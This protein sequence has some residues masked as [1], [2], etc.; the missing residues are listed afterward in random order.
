MFALDAHSKV[1]DM[2]PSGKSVLT[3]WSGYPMTAKLMLL[4][5]EQILRQAQEELELMIPGVARYIEDAALVR[6]PYEMAQFPVGSYR[7]VLD[8]QKQARRARGGLFCER[9]IRRFRHGGSG[10]QCGGGRE[11]CLR[12]GRSGEGVGTAPPQL[13]DRRD[14][15]E[16]QDIPPVVERPKGLF[17]FIVRYPVLYYR[18]GLHW[19]V[20]R[21]VL[22]LTTIGRRSGLSGSYPST[23]RRRTVPTTSCRTK[24]RTPR[25]IATWSLTQR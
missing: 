11:S 21:Q 18:L 25:G 17:R 12:L 1:P 2:C 16:G 3:V 19:L 23:T 9:R 14:D 7:R 24:G 22:L 4:T 20:S 13:P 5:D 10:R 6:H 15:V 8:F